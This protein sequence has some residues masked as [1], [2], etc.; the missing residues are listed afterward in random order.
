MA[1]ILPLNTAPNPGPATV[2]SHSDQWYS[3]NKWY[4]L[5]IGR[6]TLPD[7]GTGAFPV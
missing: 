3:G 6:L 2:Q 4:W 1:I 7:M 5:T